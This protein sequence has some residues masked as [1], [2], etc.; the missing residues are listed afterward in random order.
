M[1]KS[2]PLCSHCCLF[3]CCSFSV[4]LFKQ[5]TEKWKFS[6]C[7]TVNCENFSIF[8]WILIIFMYR[9]ELKRRETWDRFYGIFTYSFDGNLMW[10]LYGWFYGIGLVVFLLPFPS[11]Y[12][13]DDHFNNWR[14]AMWKNFKE[15]RDWG[16]YEIWYLLRRF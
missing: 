11:F 14:F 15:E 13:F 1:K 3:H 2:F 5:K 9:F 7:K 10:K 12:P 16:F 4:H 6:P 8:S